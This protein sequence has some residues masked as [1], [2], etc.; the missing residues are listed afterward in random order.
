MMIKD[1]L[2]TL[3]WIVII[4]FAFW[5]GRQLKSPNI[6]S[7]PVVKIIEK[8]AEIPEPEIKWKDRIIYKW[9]EAKPETVYYYEETYLPIEAKEGIIAQ[10]YKPNKLVFW[11]KW[12]KADTTEMESMIKKY[13]YNNIYSEFTI[14]QDKNGWYVKSRKDW[15]KKSLYLG[16]NY[17]DI[18]FIRVD[19]LFNKVLVSPRATTKKAE[20]DVGWKF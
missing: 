2:K 11:T 20:V 19:L 17:P 16:F 12:I 9:K 18:A 3:P 10:E 8:Q 6:I 15:F 5:F 7:Y 14:T 4:V 1:L 13:V